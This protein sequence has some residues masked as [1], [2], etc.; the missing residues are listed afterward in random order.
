[1]DL[2]KSP[3]SILLKHF[4]IEYLGLFTPSSD[5]EW[6]SYYLYA[7]LYSTAGGI[8]FGFAFLIVAR[9]VHN[10]MVRGFMVISAYGFILMF[11]SNQVTLVATSFPPYGTATIS[12][13]G[14]SSYLILIGLNAT[15]LS[16]S[17]DLALRKSIRKSL[18]DK[19]NLLGGIGSAEMQIETEKWVRNIGKRDYRTEHTSIHDRV[20]CENIHK[21]H[22]R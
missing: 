17:Q 4:L 7:S 5:P 15:A 6:F 2:V 13:F 12:Y 3:I 9:N 22:S 8:F 19:S 10:D 18:L 20:R 1:M 21:R 16:L 14:L 11:I